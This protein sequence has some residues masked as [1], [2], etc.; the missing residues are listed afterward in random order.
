MLVTIMLLLAGV[1]GVAYGVWGIFRWGDQRWLAVSIALL[2]LIGAPL[3]IMVATQPEGAGTAPSL[4]KLPKDSPAALPSAH[5]AFDDRV[6]P[7]GNAGAL[8]EADWSDA[9]SR[10]TFR[11]GM[12]LS[13]FRLSKLPDR[14]NAIPVC[15]KDAVLKDRNKF[16]FGIQF[17]GRVVFRNIDGITCTWMSEW[18][19]GSKPESLSEVPVI[20]VNVFSDGEYFHFL[21]PA[22]GLEPVLY[23]IDIDISSIDR[24][25]TIADAYE[26]RY[27]APAS[28][29]TGIVQNG[30]GAL[31]E[32]K[33]ILFE[34]SLSMIRLIKY[35][36]QTDGGSNK[37]TV[38]YI[39]KPVF[40]AAAEAS[41][42]V[43]AESGA[44]GL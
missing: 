14:E 29:E 40:S 31:F 5:S 21:P 2:S 32:N 33:T 26:H 4:A 34:N 9:Y 15:S 13:E 41:R 35:N 19:S 23:Y 8:S 43:A 6:A 27:G 16:P 39:L 36:G 12:T 30:F 44:E 42:Q 25:D 20:I 24:F 11:L 17:L 1:S 37:S 7:T 28:V 3:W 10:L 18:G 38:E 22:P